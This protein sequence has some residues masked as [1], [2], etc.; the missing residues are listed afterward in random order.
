VSG[1]FQLQQAAILR[2]GSHVL[3]SLGRRCGQAQEVATPDAVILLFFD[4]RKSCLGFDDGLVS[5]LYYFRRG[6][7]LWSQFPVRAIPDRGPGVLEQP[8]E[9][10]PVLCGKFQNRSR[11]V[12]GRPGGG[13][14]SGRKVRRE[15]RKAVPTSR[16]ASPQPPET[17]RSC[18][19]PAGQERSRRPLLYER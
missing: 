18:S 13:K 12:G 16:R 9:R 15:G 14:D 2:D 19:T 8:G 10:D 11:R 7:A 1:P 4:N 17:P 6:V 3:D 5:G